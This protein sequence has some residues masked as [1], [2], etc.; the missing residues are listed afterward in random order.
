MRGRVL[1]GG[2]VALPGLQTLRSDA[3]TLTL[4]HGERELFCDSG[5][6]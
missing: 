5:A 4:S 6:G 3:L 1:P 2:G